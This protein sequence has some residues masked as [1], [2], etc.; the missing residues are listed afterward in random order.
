[1]ERIE[2]DVHPDLQLIE[3][4]RALFEPNGV[5]PFEVVHLD[6]DGPKDNGW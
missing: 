4:D 2:Y 3:E 6:F 5:A 1:M